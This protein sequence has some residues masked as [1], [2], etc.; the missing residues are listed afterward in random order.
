MIL[1]ICGQNSG[2]HGLA[3]KLVPFEADILQNIG[4]FI[5]Q[6]LEGRAQVMVFKHR[7]V[8]VFYG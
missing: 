3:E 1:H 5:A 6:Q 8:V 4:A 2:Y 7:L